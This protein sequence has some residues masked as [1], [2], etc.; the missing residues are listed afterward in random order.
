MHEKLSPLLA[1]ENRNSPFF[2]GGTLKQ[3]LVSHTE[4][5][6]LSNYAGTSEYKLAHTLHYVALYVFAMEADNEQFPYSKVSTELSFLI[7]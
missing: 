1:L 5:W 7:I 6:Y 4:L 3:H 2:P